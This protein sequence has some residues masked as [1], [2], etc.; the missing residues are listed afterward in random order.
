[1]ACSHILKFNG[2]FYHNGMPAITT[3]W[4]PHGTITE[5]LEKH[6]DADRLELASLNL[7]SMP[8]FSSLH[9]LSLYSSW[10]QSKESSTSTSIA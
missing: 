6:T 5:Y 1:M 8:D 9:F 7:L 2:V 4:M 3:P 10:V